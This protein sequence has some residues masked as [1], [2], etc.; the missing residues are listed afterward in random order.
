MGLGFGAGRQ[1]GAEVK[2]K[3]GRVELEGHRTNTPRLDGRIA[4]SATEN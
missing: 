3:G 4:S 2:V 1:G